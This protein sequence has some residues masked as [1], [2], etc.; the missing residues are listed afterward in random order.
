MNFTVSKNV[1]IIQKVFLSH[2]WPY[3]NIYIKLSAQYW[4]TKRPKQDCHDMYMYILYYFLKNMV[5]QRRHI[6]MGKT[7]LE[8]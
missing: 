8:N 6:D 2:R 4:K 5:V 3:E 7:F 1:I